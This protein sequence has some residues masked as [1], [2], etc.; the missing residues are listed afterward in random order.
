[1]RM[2]PF[3]TAFLLVAPV[4]AETKVEP[5]NDPGFGAK[6]LVTAHEHM[7]VAASPLAAQAGDRMGSPLGTRAKPRLPAPRPTCSWRTA[8]PYPFARQWHQGAPSAY[9]ALCA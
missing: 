1:M 5:K 8:S 3:L 7:I 6:P 2:I 4:L 9:Q